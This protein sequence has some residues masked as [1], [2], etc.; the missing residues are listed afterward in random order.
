M[1][2][3][4]PPISFSTDLTFSPECP[5]RRLG[6]NRPLTAPAYAIALPLLLVG[7]LKLAEISARREEAV[8]CSTAEPNIDLIA[9]Y[10]YNQLLSL[11]LRSQ[12]VT[13]YCSSQ[14]EYLQRGIYLGTK[15]L[16]R[17]SLVEDETCRELEP[18]SPPRW[19]AFFRL[20]AVEIPC[21]RPA[22]DTAP[23]VRNTD[24]MTSQ[25]LFFLFVCPQ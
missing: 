1:S 24:H 5:W 15:P 23:E 2:I 20:F 4:P 9:W 16:G 18:A 21:N 25:K 3:I 11:F 10:S 19:R 22:L 7:L 14:T 17:G 12:T 6:G 8:R 13:R